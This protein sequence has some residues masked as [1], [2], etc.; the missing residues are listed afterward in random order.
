MNGHKK[1]KVTSI[2][3]EALS[4]EPLVYLL[5]SNTTLCKHHN[6]NHN[7]YYTLMLTIDNNKLRYKFPFA[8]LFSWSLLKEVSFSS[9]TQTKEL[10]FIYIF[11]ILLVI[12]VHCKAKSAKETK[13]ELIVITPLSFLEVFEVTALPYFELM[14]N[15]P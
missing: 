3:L 2:H 5:Y 12:Q 9:H 13:R 10:L 8:S 6:N 15:L 4:D 14:V 7:Q 11:H 1:L